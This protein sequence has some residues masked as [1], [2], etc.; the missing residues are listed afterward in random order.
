MLISTLRSHLRQTIHD[1]TGLCSLA[2]T[3]DAL[4][5]LE[6]LLVLHHLRLVGRN[7]GAFRRRPVPTS[8]VLSC[9]AIDLGADADSCPSAQAQIRTSPSSTPSGTHR[10]V[11]LTACVHPDHDALLGFLCKPEAHHLTVAPS[12]SWST[13][14]SRA[15]SI[16]HECP[17]S[18]RG[19]VSRDVMRA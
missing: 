3:P 7:E 6:A 12:A 17:R 2:F 16:I 11:I 19:D 18:R 15:W 14:G 8:N 1:I 5:R 9:T 4:R 10:V 13:H